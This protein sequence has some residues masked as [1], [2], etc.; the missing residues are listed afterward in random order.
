[1]SDHQDP[2]AVCYPALLPWAQ[3]S[4]QG[5]LHS[6]VRAAVER[7]LVVLWGHVDPEKPATDTDVH[8][9]V[10]ARDAY[11]QGWFDAV[12]R[13]VF[14]RPPHDWGRSPSLGTWLDASRSRARG[15][16]FRHTIAENL[17]FFARFEFQ[18]TLDLVRYAEQAARTT[19][20]TARQRAARATAG[21]L[22]WAWARHSDR[23]GWDDA[24]WYQYIEVNEL[25]GWT[26][27]ALG[28][29]GVRPTQAAERVEQIAEQAWDGWSPWTSDEL[30]ASFIA[31]AA[32][33]VADCVTTSTAT[34]ASSSALP[35]QPPSPSG[36]ERDRPDK[37]GSS[38]AM[39][40]TTNAGPSRQGP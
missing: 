5:G 17:E 3:A 39:G 20:G 6:A 35:P 28:L 27:A 15:R 21:A 31:Q 11:T 24:E 4:P 30:P 34:S 2:F 8:A 40:E 26:T 33:A 7:S 14:P 36:S 9:I 10:A 25:I 18:S 19:T 1:M 12:I 38:T 29:P 22:R 32:Q 37:S 13:P 23:L 16:A